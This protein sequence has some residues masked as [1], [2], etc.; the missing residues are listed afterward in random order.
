MTQVRVPTPLRK[1]TGGSDAVEAEGTNV[2][3][4][5]A[6]LDKRYPG[7]RERICD[8]SIVI[9]ITGNGYKTLE[10][11]IDGVEQ[12]SRI[13]AR[14]ADFDALYAQLRGGREASAG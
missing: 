1:F 2:T 5:L 10:A 11:V 8:E 13:P 9:C 12:P 4:V 6:D 3:T 7:I 14:L